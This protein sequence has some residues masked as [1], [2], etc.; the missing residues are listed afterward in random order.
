MSQE[1]MKKVGKVNWLLVSLCL[2]VISSIG[3]QASLTGYKG[4]ATNGGKHLN[5][6]IDSPHF[7]Q[8]DPR[9]KSERLGYTRAKLEDYGCTLCATA[10]SL[11]AIGIEC[12]PK[13]LN[14]TLRNN[15]GYTSSG[16]LRWSKLEKLSEGNFRIVQKNSASHAYI[17]AQLMKNIPVIAKVQWQGQFWHW[18]LITGKKGTQYLIADPLAPDQAHRVA[19]YYPEGFFS[20]RHLAAPLNTK[21]AS[22]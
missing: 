14:E 9:W 20:V 10:M 2:F 13:T 6:K 22:R 1:F 17:D 5:I 4:T 3:V 12:T 8:Y 16:K 18:V 21:L 7:S 19:D 11:N 15:S